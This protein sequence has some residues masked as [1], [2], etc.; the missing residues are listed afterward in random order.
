MAPGDAAFNR[1][2]PPRASAAAQQR[3]RVIV[4]ATGRMKQL[5]QF[6]H[7]FNCDCR[8]V[9]A[10]N[11]DD[12]EHNA[13]YNNLRHREKR[14]ATPSCAATV[15]Y[16]AESEGKSTRAWGLFADESMDRGSFVMEYV[17]EVV[18]KVVDEA[19]CKRRL[20]HD[21]KKFYILKLEGGRKG[22][23]IDA[24][25]RGGPARFMNQLWTMDG[26]LYSTFLVGSC[27]FVLAGYVGMVIGTFANARTVLSLAISVFF[28]FV[29]SERML[30]LHQH[31]STKE[32][33]VRLSNGLQGCRGHGMLIAKSKMQNAKMLILLL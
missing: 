32:P 8:H 2:T 33:G 10:A 24:T 21:G 23:S 20:A 29:A 31:R 18:V 4:G 28:S 12:C 14:R 3:A 19:E 7:E 25:K 1:R 17:C 22:E 15:A 6:A 11:G 5:K 26:E 16:S 9:H 13:C 27:T 30:A